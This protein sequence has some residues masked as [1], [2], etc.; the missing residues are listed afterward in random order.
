[1][2]LNM[3]TADA[4]EYLFVWNGQR[5][6]DDALCD[7]IATT[8]DEAGL[9]LNVSSLRHSLCALQQVT[10]QVH[11]LFIFILRWLLTNSSLATTDAVL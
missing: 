6:T 5:P 8:M 2:K 10:L 1:M 7:A 4:D 11:F 3:A 9:T